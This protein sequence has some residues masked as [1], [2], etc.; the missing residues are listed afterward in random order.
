VCN[1][2]TGNYVDFDGDEYCD[3]QFEVWDTTE[4]PLDIIEELKWYVD[5]Y[6]NRHSREIK[7]KLKYCKVIAVYQSIEIIG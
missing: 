2:Q 6:N 7:K 3:N 4:T 5:N 1:T